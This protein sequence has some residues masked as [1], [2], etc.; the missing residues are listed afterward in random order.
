ML[1]T[2]KACQ[3]QLVRRHAGTQVRRQRPSRSVAVG[4]CNQLVSLQ[5]DRQSV[6]E[7]GAAV[8]ATG[9]LQWLDGYS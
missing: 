4:C 6:A 9:R 5:A 8:A 2:F 7:G 1:P 3:V